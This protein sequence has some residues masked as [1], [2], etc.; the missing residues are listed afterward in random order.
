MKA[1]HTLQHAHFLAAK[2]PKI[3]QFRTPCR[4]SL[5]CWIPCAHPSN[6]PHFP[7]HFISAQKTY[8]YNR[9]LHQQHCALPV[10]IGV[11]IYTFKFKKKMQFTTNAL[12]DERNLVIF[13][14]SNYLSY[15]K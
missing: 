6:S 2:H 8:L 4:D 3:S 13:Y 1:L 12:P 15:Q 7:D 11:D 9:E 5:V 10:E 14:E